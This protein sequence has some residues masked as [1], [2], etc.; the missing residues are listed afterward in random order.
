MSGSA[1]T[2]AMQPV[3]IVVLK[4]ERSLEDITPE[5]KPVDFRMVYTQEDG[6]YLAQIPLQESLDGGIYT[7]YISSVGEKRKETVYLINEEQSK[8]ALEKLNAAT[9]ENEVKTVLLENGE[10]FGQDMDTVKQNIDLAGKIIFSR[11]PT[12]GFAEA[13]EV[14]S[15]LEEA[16]AIGEIVRAASV[17]EFDAIMKARAQILKVDYDTFSLLE[18]GVKERLLALLKEVDYEEEPFARYYEKQ[19]PLAKVQGASSWSK[20]KQAVL[21]NA[22][23]LGLDLSSDSDYH[24][25]KDPDSVFQKMYRKSL[26]SIEAVQEAFAQSIEEALK[27]QQGSTAG[28]NTGNSGSSGGGGGGSSGAGSVSHVELDPQTVEQGAV[29]GMGFADIQGHWAQRAIVKLQEAGAISGFE[30]GTFRPEQEITRAEF[31]KLVVSAFHLEAQAQQEYQD[32]AQTDWFAPY[33]SVATALELVNGYD[34]YFRPNDFISRQD[35]AV[36]LYRLLHSMGESISGNVE[37]DDVQEIAPYAKEAVAALG[38]AGVIKGT[39]HGFEPQ[40]YTTRAQVAQMIVNV[41]DYMGRE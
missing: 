32:V 25:V 17:E 30:D 4:G 24:N 21:E 19:L 1:G 3:D 14:T 28:G 41:M 37:F 22:Q 26:A 9:D 15:L 5:E 6:A 35:C 23:E 16:A 12:G 10:A 34:G 8:P 33:V 18:Q 29:L 2:Q 31:V 7:I 40:E 20:L 13:A 11:R 36:I 27:E 38:A 39:E